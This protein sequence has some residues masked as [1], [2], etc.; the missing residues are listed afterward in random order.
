MKDR[1]QKGPR[2]I[3]NE[4]AP[5]SMKIPKP[6]PAQNNGNQGSVKE[7]PPKSDNKK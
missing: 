3:S 6:K 5:G 1:L 4:I 2:L 7:T